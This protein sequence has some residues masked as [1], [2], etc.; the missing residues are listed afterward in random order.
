M[1]STDV[2]VAVVKRAGCQSLCVGQAFPGRWANPGGGGVIYNQL[3]MWSGWWFEVSERA[4]LNR[5]TTLWYL[6]YQSSG[7]SGGMQPLFLLNHNASG[8]VLIF[9]SNLGLF[10]HWTLVIITLCWQ[11]ALFHSI[12]FPLSAYNKMH[13]TFLEN[14]ECF[15]TSQPLWQISFH[16]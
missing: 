4:C 5:C 11:A 9:P 10:C 8:N 12:L 15:S 13:H 7:G 14:L 6:W 2:C 1:S 3:D 16:G